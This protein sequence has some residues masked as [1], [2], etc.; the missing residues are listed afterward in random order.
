MGYTKAEQD[1]TSCYARAKDDEPIFVLL[2]R[3]PVAWLLVMQWAGLRQALGETDEQQVKDAEACGQAMAAYCDGL[4]KA[5]KR[6]TAHSAFYLLYKQWQADD[7]V[8]LMTAELQGLRAINQEQRTQLGLS[9]LLVDAV[10]KAAS[11]TEEELAELCK[12]ESF[13]ATDAFQE[14]VSLRRATRP[15]LA[16]LRVTE[17]KS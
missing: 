14:V 17:G 15:L 11:G 1:D 5:A 10:T 8:K 4:G 12:N 13:A 3:D 6:A 9:K 16:D 2:A 7:R